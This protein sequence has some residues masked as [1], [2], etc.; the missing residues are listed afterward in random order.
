M[1]GGGSSSWK[2]LPTHR[3]KIEHLDAQPARVKAETG[4]FSLLSFQRVKTLTVVENTAFPQENG[5]I[6]LV[7]REIAR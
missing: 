3:S 4:I 1:C 2:L 5:V 7:C 6:N